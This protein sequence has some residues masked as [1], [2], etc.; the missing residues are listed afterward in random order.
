MKGLE[1]DVT[2]DR[3]GRIDL[4]RLLTVSAPPA[5]KPM[6]ATPVQKK[7]AQGSAG[8]SAASSAATPAGRA[9]ALQLALGELDISGAAVRYTDL[10]P[11]GP[12]AAGIDKFDA[13]L[14]KL[15]LD[16]GARRVGIGE[17]V[18]GS[19]NFQV[20]HDKPEAAGIPGGAGQVR[21]GQLCRRRGR[22]GR[23]AR[24]RRLMSSVSTVSP[25]T[26]GR[27][28]WK[29]AARRSRRPPCWRRLR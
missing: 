19:A 11:A 23:K 28:G 18:S 17:I 22:S 14:R 15:T 7:P 16:T 6:E 3:Q 10:Q 4:Q 8:V 21:A 2:R 20:R 27:P 9:G 1:A 13:T 26:T 25:S 29:I 24:R 5:A 12:L